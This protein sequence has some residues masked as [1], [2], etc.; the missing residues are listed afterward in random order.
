MK[1]KVKEGV[2]RVLDS[3]E[4]AFLESKLLDE[5]TIR[6]L[7]KVLAVYVIEVY[8]AVKVVGKENV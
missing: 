8:H 2:D 5:E 1:A 3:I 7:E 4:Y 6:E